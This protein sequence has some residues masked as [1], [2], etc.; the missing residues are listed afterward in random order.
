[1]LEG[2]FCQLHDQ[3]D[4]GNEPDGDIVVVV[5]ELTRARNPVVKPDFFIGAVG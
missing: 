3:R 1:M 5:H 4:G 2:G